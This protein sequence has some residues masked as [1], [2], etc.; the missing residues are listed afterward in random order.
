MAKKQT[1]SKKTGTD[2]SIQQK[3]TADLS[4][5][6][7]AAPQKSAAQEKTAQQ[8]TAQQKTAQQKTAQQKTARR[9]KSAG[10]GQT[11][12]QEAP[13]ELPTLRRPGFPIVGLGASAGG[14]EALQEFFDAMPKDSGMAFVVVTHQHPG[15]ASML[16]ELLARHTQ[17]PCVEAGDATPIERDHVYVGPP[18]SNLAMLNG[19]LHLLNVENSR[20]GTPA[21]TTPQQ[22]PIDGFLRSL[23]EDQGERAVCIILSGT[24]TDGTLG[25]NAIKAESGMAMVQDPASANYSGMPSSA[26]AAGLADYVTSPREMPQHLLAYTKAPYLA[27][28]DSAV[29]IPNGPL[30]KIFLLLRSRTGNDFS[31][32]KP[33]TIRRRIERRMSVHQIQG[34]A[35]YVKYL[36]NN[37]HEVDILFKELLI[38][39]TSFFRDFDAWAELAKTGLL[40][41]I[42]SRPDQY[43]FRVWIPGCATGE[44]A[45]TLAILLRETAEQVGRRL[46]YQIFGTDLDAG[47]IETARA[48][49][50]P[51]G[52]AVDVTRQRLD[53]FFTPEVATYRVR[54][55]VREMCVFAPQNVIKDPPFTKLDVICCRNLLIY[56]NADMQQ[57]LL[58]IFHYALKP[59]GLLM[60]GPSET[61]GTQRGLFNPVDGKWKIFARREV[62]SSAGPPEIP[63]Q[64][65]PADAALAPGETA[66]ALPTSRESQ[67]GAMVNRLLLSRFAP[68][69]IVVNERGD[70]LYIHG[71]TGLYLEPASGQPKMN[72]IE[73]AREGLEIE[74][75]TCLRQAAA[76]DMDAAN[77]KRECVR[78]RPNGG[79]MFI[80]INVTRI[81]DPES[82]RGLFL[83]T[84]QPPTRPPSP[85][86]SRKA[87]EARPPKAN[88]TPL[89]GLSANC[90]TPA[91][92]CRPP[93]KSWKRRMRN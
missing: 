30:Q 61:I 75:S 89:P 8:K 18:G 35:A 28:A 46:D 10:T 90:N 81:V 26:I 57:R 48:G 37:A 11:A 9:K 59:G 15:H 68:A 7:R 93:S 74:R 78:I 53:R 72:V 12:L 23:A 17:M 84:L 56:L 54:K 31:S 50:Y 92:H 39:V 25:L 91:S 55:E 33:T 80:D 79:Y 88:S 24:G 45:Y 86:R 38:S 14:L 83:I 66:L 71:R 58:P 41:L 34:P 62:L 67:I 22:L 2:R 20:T 70:I 65:V 43:G 6:K 42:E 63:A 51:E 76:A 1:G 77:V 44:E 87:N 73:M 4:N 29:E 49:V 52:I 47:A 85:R 16:A 32:Y 19:T 40:R 3:A 13:V 69:S 60:L 64:R 82:I 27:T 21:V 36:Q 5:T